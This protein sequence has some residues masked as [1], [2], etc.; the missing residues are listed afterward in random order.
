MQE[1]EPGKVKNFD[2]KKEAEVKRLTDF[3]VCT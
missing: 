3:K 1:D 2:N